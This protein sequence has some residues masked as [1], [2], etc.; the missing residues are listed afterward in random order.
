MSPGLSGCTRKKSDQEGL[1]EN[2]EAD[3][4]VAAQRP[5]SD[6]ASICGRRC[7][8]ELELQR[9]RMWERRRGSQVRGKLLRRFL[10][11][12]RRRRGLR[13]VVVIVPAAHQMCRDFTCRHHFV[14]EPVERKNA[15]S[16]DEKRGQQERYGSSCDP[17]GS[18][19][20]TASHPSSWNVMQILVR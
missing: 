10:P 6:E 7:Y 4:L 20:T 11:F 14:D 18:N 19:Q 16:D 13:M 15:A 8:S 17:G 9:H 1:V 3:I 12:L 2:D 5:E